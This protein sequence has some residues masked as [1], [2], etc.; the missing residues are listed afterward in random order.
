[1]FLYPIKTIHTICSISRNEINVRPE[2][3]DWLN[4]V[5]GNDGWDIRWLYN[6]I[7]AIAT[8][9]IFYDETHLL[10]FKLAF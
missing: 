5:I 3:I 9:I 8:D 1:M 6:G 7:W 4:E 10:A 2:V